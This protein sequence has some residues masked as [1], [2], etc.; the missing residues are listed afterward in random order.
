MTSYIQQL[1]N[2]LVDQGYSAEVPGKK[3]TFSALL[4]W[5]EKDDNLIGQNEV[6]MFPDL[7]KEKWF[8]FEI[9]RNCGTVFSASIVD[10]VIIH[11]NKTALIIL[12]R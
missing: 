12:K 2:N 3:G 8:I 7:P 1:L 11:E 9:G 5:G 10:S 6:S 4:R